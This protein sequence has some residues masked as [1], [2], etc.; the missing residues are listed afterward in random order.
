MQKNIPPDIEKA[1]KQEFDDVQGKWDK[2]KA[3]VSKDLHLLEEITPKLRT[4][5]ADS[6][7]IEKWRDG[8]KD[9]LRTEQ[10]AQGDAEG[11]QR[12]LDRCSTFVNEIDTIETS[13]KHER[14]RD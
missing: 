10:A 7:V 2:L 4:F 1:Y 6:K 8:V 12:Q 11:L 13:E 3:K 9:F 5:E 14:S